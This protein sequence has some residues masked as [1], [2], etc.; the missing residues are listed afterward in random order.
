MKV[1]PDN[2]SISLD[3]FAEAAEQATRGGQDGQLTIVLDGEALQIRAVGRLPSQREVGWVRT[4]EGPPPDA[5]RMFLEQLQASF[6][7]GISA[8]VARELGLEPAPG[9]PLDARQVTRA[10]D[11]AST[12]QAA[13]SGINFL[14]RMAFSA[15]APGPQFEA[16]CESAGTRAGDLT[17]A[18]RE[19]IDAA[20]G[21]AFAAA[22]NGDTVAV[23][24]AQAAELM[25]AAI[26]EVLAASGGTPTTPQGS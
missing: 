11:M 16:L 1:S 17:A 18:Q 24:H 23:D 6:G 9:K 2:P 8:S 14:S 20:F 21:R 12:A 22:S 10:I 7:S 19:A 26:A 4:G 25:R 3:R 15:Q 5:L 13:Y